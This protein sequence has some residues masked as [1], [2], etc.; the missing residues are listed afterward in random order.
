MLRAQKIIVTD[1]KIIVRL[2]ER[3]TP[4]L[5]H[6]ENHETFH[7]GHTRTTGGQNIIGK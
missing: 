4:K 5:V 1:A 7:F 3:T 6:E 2:T